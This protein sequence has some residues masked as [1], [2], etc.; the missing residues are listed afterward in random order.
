MISLRAG[1]KVGYGTLAWPAVCGI[2]MG[3]AKVVSN[4]VGERELGH[5]GR[6]TRVVIHEGDDACTRKNGIATKLCQPTIV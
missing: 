2:V 6:H 3:R 5:L 1:L 4:L